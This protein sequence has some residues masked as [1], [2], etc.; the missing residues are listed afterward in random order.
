MTD[1]SVFLYLDPAASDDDKQ[2]GTCWFWVRDDRCLIHRAHDIVKATASCCYHLYG[3]P[4]RA[5]VRPLGLT[6]PKESGLVDREVRCE[7]CLWFDDDSVCNLF[8]LLNRKLPDV[9][10]LD[11]KVKPKGCC[12]AQEP[13]ESKDREKRL[14]DQEL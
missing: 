11:I 13:S 1:R 9:W 5:G 4:H 7:N 12:N 14:K 3:P 6:T 2:C 8:E 10:D